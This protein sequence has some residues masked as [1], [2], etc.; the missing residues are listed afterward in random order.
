MGF[1]DSVFKLCKVLQ[2]CNFKSELEPIMTNLTFFKEGQETPNR[3][4]YGYL[5]RGMRN[6]FYG[7]LFV[8]DNKESISDLRDTVPLNINEKSLLY[9]GHMVLTNFILA[10]LKDIITEA[11]LIAKVINPYSNYKPIQRM[12]VNECIES[13]VYEQC[14]IDFRN[15]KVYKTLLQSPVWN[16]IKT[17]SLEHV[18]LMIGVLDRD[19]IN[20]PLNNVPED[21]RNY[22][23]RTMQPKLSIEDILMRDFCL[24]LSLR[25]ML[26]NAC[27][28]F[29]TAL[30]GGE[31]LILNNDN[32][33]SIDK[34]ESNEIYSY[35]TVFVQGII[36]NEFSDLVGDILL[37]DCEYTNEYKIH[38]FGRIHSATISFSQEEGETTKLTFCTLND[39]LNP[40]SNL[41]RLS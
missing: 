21:I 13:S 24:I 27:Q 14:A 30:V 10:C 23:F 3:S 7:F 1:R 28:L 16:N 6:Q 37:I 4:S 5:G 39:E 33:I 17:M 25:E 11:P 8:D 32:L 29:Y 22:T 31:L 2:R 38:E 26:V 12:S 41:V 9:Q 20:N 18:E 19:I 36:F 35:M 40:I 34:N 15:T